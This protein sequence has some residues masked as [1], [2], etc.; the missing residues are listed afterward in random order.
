MTD[1]STTDDSKLTVGLSGRLDTVTAPDLEAQLKGCLEGVSELILDLNEL[2]Y[3]SSAGLRVLHA[4][5]KSLSAGGRRLVIRG[6]NDLV[7]EVFEVTG[8]T[9]ILNIE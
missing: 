8:F 9:G 1:N 2:E 7:R 6:A 3:I 5:H 4:T